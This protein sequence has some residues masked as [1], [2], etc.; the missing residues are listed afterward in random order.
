[1]A[2]WSYMAV[3]RFLYCSDRQKNQDKL[4]GV[5]DL[6]EAT[7]AECLCLSYAVIKLKMIRRHI[8]VFNVHQPASRNNTE[9]DQ[10]DTDE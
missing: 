7:S 10:A 3:F 2:Q 4:K 6:I 5:F 8:I 1:M 9:T